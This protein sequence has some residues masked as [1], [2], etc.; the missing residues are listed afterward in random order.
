MM[1]KLA[2]AEPHK[3]C[4]KQLAVVDFVYGVGEFQDG[5]GIM[6]ISKMERNLLGYFVIFFFYSPSIGGFCNWVN[7]I[8]SL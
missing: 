8:F 7:F 3:P 6:G 2:G 1:R 5:M 4:P